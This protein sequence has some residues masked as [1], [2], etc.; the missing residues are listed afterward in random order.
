MVYL[1]SYNCCEAFIDRSIREKEMK[2]TIYINLWR[3]ILRSNKVVIILKKGSF[4][5]LKKGS[6]PNCF[7]LLFVFN[8][9]GARTKTTKIIIS[10]FLVNQQSQC[11][12]STT[13]LTQ[14][15]LRQI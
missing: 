7:I 3:N 11:C 5:F 10:H 9:L 2:R 4:Q 13:V 15:N 14:G 1:L 8:G 6:S 12:N